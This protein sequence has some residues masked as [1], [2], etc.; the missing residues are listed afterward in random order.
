MRPSK[1]AKTVP[2]RRRIQRRL[3][4]AIG[5]MLA[6]AALIGVVVAGYAADDSTTAAPGG[7]GVSDGQSVGTAGG[8]LVK[9]ASWSGGGSVDLAQPGKPTV[10]LAM[11]GW[12]PTCIGP[13][14][15]LKAVHAEFGDRV[16]VIAVSVDPGETEKTLERF[17]EAAGNPEYLWAFD[18]DGA[19]ASTFELRYLDTVIVLD[20]AGNQLHQSVRPSNDELREVLAGALG[21]AR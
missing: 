10:V 17:R 21:E 5:A 4:V 3:L 2:S 20:S 15:D 9:L 19:F 18:S 13:A 11:A 16:N 7:T 14:R 1:R 6:S 8:A 12:C